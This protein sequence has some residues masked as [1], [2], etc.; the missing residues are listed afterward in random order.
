MVTLR[1]CL[2]T[3]KGYCQVAKALLFLKSVLWSHALRKIGWA[4]LY[5][6]GSSKKPIEYV[7]LTKAEHTV[8]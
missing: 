4:L 7:L 1:L 8:E 2:M 5:I 3:F 6:H